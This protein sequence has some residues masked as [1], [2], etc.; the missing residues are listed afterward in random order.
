MEVHTG[1]P[2]GQGT[3]CRLCFLCEGVSAGHGGVHDVTPFLRL[4]DML[5]ERSW[6]PRFAMTHDV[7]FQIFYC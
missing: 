7:V 6:Q 3:T 5:S 1:A 2:A 4:G